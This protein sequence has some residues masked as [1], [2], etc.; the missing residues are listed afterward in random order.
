MEGW[1]FQNAFQIISNEDV[2]Q[3][4]EWGSLSLRTVGLYE[5]RTSHG[6][7]LSTYDRVYS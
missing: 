2:M 1:E 6:P 5:S 3:H 7:H 4:R